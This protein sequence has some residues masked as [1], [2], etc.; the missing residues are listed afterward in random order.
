MSFLSV[1]PSLILWLSL[2]FYIRPG[3]VLPFLGAMAFHELGHIL[4]L[5][6]MKKPPRRLTLTFAGARLEMP[7]LGYRQTIWAAAGGP[8]FSLL[9]GLLLPLAPALSLY[10]LA[11]GL[12]NLLPLSG[13]DGGRMLE[14]F[15]LLRLPERK[16]EGLFRGV[17]LTVAG[18]LCLLAVVS[19]AKFQLGLWPILLAA[20]LLLKALDSGKG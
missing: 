4:A 16:A 12:F 18:C 19:A 8:V 14:N 3:L 13:L 1:H 17:S 10:S 2:L 5:V 11:L 9:L 7:P 6:L 20:V 15:L